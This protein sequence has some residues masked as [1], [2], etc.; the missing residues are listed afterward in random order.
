M[1]RLT[2]CVLAYVEATDRDLTGLEAEDRIVADAVF[3]G[4]LL[5]R[6]DDKICTLSESRRG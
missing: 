3:T 1:L 5:I 6:R 4:S 2:G